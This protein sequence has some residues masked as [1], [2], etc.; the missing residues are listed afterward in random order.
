MK[1]DL[2]PEIVDRIVFA[3]EDQSADYSVDVDT[4]EMVK[5]QGAHLGDRFVSIPPWRPLDGFQLMERFVATLRNP[6]HRGRLR[7]A[8]SSG[9]RVFR[10]FKDELK[11]SPYL[12]QLWYR[13]KMTEM[14]RVVTEWY[15]TE[16]R[17]RGL[18]RLGPEPEETDDL[19]ASEFAFG[20]ARSCEMA[21]VARLQD[22]LSAAGSAPR[23]VPSADDPRAL[24]IVARCS[25]PGIAGFIAGRRADDGALSIEAIAVAPDFQGLGVGQA[26]LGHFIDQGERLGVHA[27]QVEL[28]GPEQELATMFVQQG[29]SAVAQTLRLSL[30]PTEAPAPEA[31]AS[32]TSAGAAPAPAH[33]RRS[34]P[35]APAR[36]T[37]G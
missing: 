4:A 5:D 34:R 1:F 20:R 21:Y 11:R 33:P 12:E 35:P 16:R 17:S 9:G 23:S 14:R 30:A 27:I 31:A 28:A 36:S 32:R 24:V 19:L 26:L 15:D 10:T 2:I 6:V 18:A 3:M 8:L 22:A 37:P 13:F 7:E 29:F 25:Q